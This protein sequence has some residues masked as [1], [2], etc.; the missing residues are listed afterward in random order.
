ML[1]LCAGDTAL[2]DLQP[3]TGWDL[4]VVASMRFLPSQSEGTQRSL[5]WELQHGGTA[6]CGAREWGLPK[7]G[8]LTAGDPW[9]HA[10][11]QDA[12]TC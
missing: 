1:G 8:F 4:L 12:W 10:V 2:Q 5:S 11:F 7:S 3:G 9:L 6:S